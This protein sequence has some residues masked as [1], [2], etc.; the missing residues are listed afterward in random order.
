MGE[1]ALTLFAGLTSF[2]VFAETFSRAPG[3][4]VSVPSYVKKVVFP[5]EL[6]PLVILGSA[7]INSLICVG[8]IIVA[9]AILFKTVSATIFLLPLVYIPLI[10][11]SAG[12]AWFL[13]SL[14]VFI[15]DIDQATAIVAQILL[16]ISPVF[17]TGST[18][19]DWLQ[20]VM[21]FNPMTVIL[22][23][24][25]QTLLW[26]EGLDWVAWSIWTALGAIVAWGGLAW[27]LKTKKGFADV[28]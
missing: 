7:L 15:R 11:F 23:G 4:I 27:F 20:V 24:F 3:A 22:S 1:F 21:F 19:P 2:T 5:L 16:Y 25:R 17:Y 13:A 12:V 14:G 18:L 10:L 28:I 8:I 9:A 26:G 6:L